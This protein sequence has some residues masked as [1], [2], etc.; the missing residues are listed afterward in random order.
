VIAANGNGL[1]L[2]VT[3]ELIEAMADRVAQILAEGTADTTED[4]YL[5]VAGAASFLS[6]PASRIYALVSARRLPHH[7]DGSR[8]L[9]DRAEL[10]R[11]VEN[12]GAK[13][14]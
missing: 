5:D 7:R 4:G 8:L 3:D 11:Y 6:C 2:A 13:R 14:P 12:G 10:R 1:A 9:F